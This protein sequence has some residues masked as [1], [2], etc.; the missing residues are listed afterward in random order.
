[1]AYAYLEDR[2]FARAAELLSR[3][4]RLNPDDARVQYYSAV[5]IQQD[6][7]SAGRPEPAKIAAMQR[8]LQKAIAIEPAFAAAYRLLAL[9]YEWQGNSEKSLQAIKR[10]TQLNP[11]NRVFRAELS[12][13]SGGVES[14]TI[15]QQLEPPHSRVATQ[16]SGK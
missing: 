15:L 12:R 2:D 8:R 9:T 4:E 14:A 10:A 1:L 7:E 6:A 5:L 16:A 13:M 3:A 11:R